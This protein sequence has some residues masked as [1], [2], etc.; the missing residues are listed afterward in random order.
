MLVKLAICLANN[1]FR[2]YKTIDEVLALE[3]PDGE[4]YQLEWEPSVLNTSLYQDAEGQIDA[5]SEFS[6]Q[7]RALGFRA[8][9]VRPPV[10]HDFR[11]QGL[12]LIGILTFLRLPM[13]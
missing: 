6:T 3:P 12:Y 8:G 4:M 10:Q 7:L 1:A 13:P 2:D 11:A 9:Y 5:A